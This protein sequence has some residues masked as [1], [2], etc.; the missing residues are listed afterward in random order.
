MNI[1]MAWIHERSC[2]NQASYSG[3]DAARTSSLN[4]LSKSGTVLTRRRMF[5]PISCHR[6]RRCT[7]PFRWLLHQSWQLSY[8][9]YRIT[10]GVGPSQQ[11]TWLPPSL[12]GTA[13]VSA[14]AFLCLPALPALAAV[15]VEPSNALSLPTW[16]IH[17]SSTVE[18][19]T[20]M[21]L[22][23][24]YAEVTGQ[25]N[26]WPIITFLAVENSYED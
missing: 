5:P 24:R 25:L 19:A 4:I 18:W 9:I 2:P 21:L 3:R 6:K 1:C 20:A 23:W 11:S 22:F 7:T 12:S 8:R 15:H 14:V 13:V 17:I 26:P 16:A 10:A